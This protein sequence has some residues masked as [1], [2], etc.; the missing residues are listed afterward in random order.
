M[1]IL[2][3]GSSGLV[4]SALYDLL[5]SGGHEVFRLVRKNPKNEK[6]IN[7]LPPEDK[8]SAFYLDP[9]KIEGFDAIVHL[10]GENIANKRWS[11]K[12]KEKIYNSRVLATRLLAETISSLKNPPEVF[13]SASAIGFYGDREDNSM[14]EES[15]PGTDFLSETCRDWEE[16]SKIRN[17]TRVVNV[18]IG[19]VLDPKGGALAKM[20]PIFNLGAGGNLG[21]GKQWMSWI[22]LDD[23]IAG[24]RHCLVNKDTSGPINLV[25]P[26]P[27]KNNEFTKTLAKV[28][29]MPAIFPAPGFVLRIVLGEMADALLLSST[30][31]SS[32]KLV[33]SGFE[34]TYPDLEPALRHM[35][36]K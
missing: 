11:K 17:G 21:N 18:R 24:I 4:G 14:S 26:N 9:S 6:E 36:G 2:L 7:W 19:A 30:K 29:G 27:V 32:D 34:F 20:L 8:N 22:A 23:L 15:E 10:A 5:S 28:L 25:A 3:S 35:L 1:K 12:Q 13:I 31:V 16:A 33:K